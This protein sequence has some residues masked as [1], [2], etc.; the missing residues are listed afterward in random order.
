MICMDGS[1]FYSRSKIVSSYQS[2]PRVREIV[3]CIANY[4][5]ASKTRSL[6]SLCALVKVSADHSMLTPK[7]LRS[8]TG[9]K[10]VAANRKKL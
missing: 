6:N 10:N 9:R 1:L 4:E 2:Q 7:P 8:R 5:V 3:Q